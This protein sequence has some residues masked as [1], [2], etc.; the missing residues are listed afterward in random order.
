MN[1]KTDSI[2]V[3]ISF[4]EN[5][6]EIELYNFLKSQSSLIGYSGY[7]KM[8]LKKEMEKLKNNSK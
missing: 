4:K 3:S 7:I 6:E 2:R 1:N 8:L 5:I